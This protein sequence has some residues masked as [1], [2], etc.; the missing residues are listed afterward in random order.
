MFRVVPCFQE[1]AHFK[2]ET[3]QKLD[4]KLKSKEELFKEIIEEKD[5]KILEIK[6]TLEFMNDKIKSL[7]TEL[8]DVYNKKQKKLIKTEALHINL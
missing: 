3:K 4:D 6:S 2:M 7:E 1:N 5:N 8:L